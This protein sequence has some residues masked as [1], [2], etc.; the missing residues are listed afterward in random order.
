MGGGVEQI[1]G[2]PTRT[3]H[4][5]DRLGDLPLENVA[6][7]LC[8]RQDGTVLVEDPPFRVRRCAGCGLGYTSPR[9]HAERLHELYG[10]RYWSSE[11]ARHFGYTSY[12]EEEKA[13][14]RTFRRRARLVR[15]AVPPGRLLEVGCAAGYFLAVMRDLGY[16]V[17]GVEISGE[18][19]QSARKRFGLDAVHACRL[20]DAPYPAGSFD[21]VAMWDVVEHLADPLAELAH[22]HRLLRPGGALVLQTQDLDS[23]ARRVMGR[24]WHHFKQLEHLYHFDRRTLR[25]LL[26][27][28]EFDVQQETRRAAGKYVSFEFLAERSARFGRWA[29]LLAKP[30]ALLG[31]RYLY[32]NPLDEL[33]VVARRREA[34]SP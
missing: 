20:G 14:L 6:C 30:L 13:Y 31:R 11:C 22:C 34:S 33:I 7:Y 17:H 23:L 12:L 21:L 27:R 8:G 5:V 18:A 1:P 32:V 3:G 16:E 15:R 10:E 25:E 2:T 4:M 24:R 9:V 26:G 19:V 29:E 28:A